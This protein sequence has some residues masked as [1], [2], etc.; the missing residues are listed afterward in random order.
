MELRDAE[1]LPWLAARTRRA[2]PKRVVWLQDD[3]THQRFYWLELPA[4]FAAAAGQQLVAN[5]QDNQISLSGTVPAG[6]RL[7]LDD[8][9]L[10]LTKPVTVLVDDQ[11]RFHGIVPRTAGALFDDLQQRTDPHLAGSAVLTLP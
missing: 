7:H 1:S 3:V 9:L 5:V 10:D 11:Q 4:G 6:L 8:T 2:W